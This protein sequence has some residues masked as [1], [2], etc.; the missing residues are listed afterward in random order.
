MARPL[1][2]QRGILALNSIHQTE[3]RSACSSGNLQTRYGLVRKQ[4]H[5]GW[6]HFS[7]GWLAQTE[8]LGTSNASGSGL[9]YHYASNLPTVNSKVSRATGL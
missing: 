1:T 6:S 3:P 2:L 4:W 7:P 9:G 8:N 5:C